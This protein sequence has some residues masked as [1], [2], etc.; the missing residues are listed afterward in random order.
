MLLD[1][2][3]ESCEKFPEFGEQWADSPRY[4]D[5]IEKKWV[6]DSPIRDCMRRIGENNGF[7][8]FQK[9]EKEFDEWLIAWVIGAR[10]M[11]KTDAELQLACMLYLRYGLKTMWLRN[12]DVELQDRRFSE[13][14]LADAKKFGWCPAEWVAKI[15]G[16]YSSEDKDEADKIIDF[17]AISTFGNRRGGAHPRTILMVLDEF[18]PEDRRYPPMPAIG[19]MSLSKTVLAGNRNARIICSSNFTEGSNPYFVQYQIYPEQ[20]RDITICAGRNII[21]RA[22]GYRMSIDA[23]NPWTDNYLQGKYADY[24]S[25]KEDPTTTLIKPVPKGSQPGPWILLKDGINYR[26]WIKNGILYWDKFNG[27][28]GNTVVYTSELKETSESS[29]IIPTW[30]L[31]QLKESYEVGVMRFKTP[32]I[33]FAVMSTIYDAF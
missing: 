14:F 15:D 27:K 33:L 22:R 2:E 29:L 16:V 12:K 4:W 28:T 3:I 21:E 1:T 13:S 32:N 20:G 30:L 25:E 11:G 8:N 24:A 7:Y 19:L 17:Q 31:K 10:R 26:Y 6:E 18:M 9:L 5:Y 23:E